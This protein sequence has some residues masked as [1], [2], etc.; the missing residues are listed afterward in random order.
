MIKVRRDCVL[1][2]RVNSIYRVSFRHSRRTCLTVSLSRGDYSLRE[3]Q[4]RRRSRWGGCLFITPCVLNA[5]AGWLSPNISMQRLKR[6]HR[7]YSNAMSAPLLP[8]ALLLL[9]IP[10]SRALFSSSSFCFFLPPFLFLDRRKE[11]AR[12]HTS[13]LRG[14]KMQR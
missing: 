8:P 12:L 5:Y 4:R 7:V 11:A 3:I 6:L 10:F 13:K 14:T 9:S 2:K 1:V